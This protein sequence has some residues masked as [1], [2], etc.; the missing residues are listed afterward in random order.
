MISAEKKAEYNRRYYDQKRRK[1]HAGKLAPIC[2]MRGP[3]GKVVTCKACMAVAKAREIGKRINE[4]EKK[5]LDALYRAKHAQEAFQWRRRNPEKAR[6][7][8]RRWRERNRDL[9]KIAQRDWYQR[10]QERARQA[11]RDRYHAKRIQGG[12]GAQA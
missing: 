9:A 10:N 7:A 6:A 2:G 11:S 5:R 4:W 8:S 12:S 3:V 1:V